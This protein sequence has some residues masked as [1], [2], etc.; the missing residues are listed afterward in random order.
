MAIKSNIHSLISKLQRGY[1][2]NSTLSVEDIDASM[3]SVAQA[4]L[5][6]SEGNGEAVIENPN[7]AQVS[8]QISD[9]MADVE[10]ESNESF[11]KAQRKAGIITGLMFSKPKEFIQRLGNPKENTS[12]KGNVVASEGRHIEAPEMMTGETMKL[13]LEAFDGTENLN[14]VYYNIAVNITASKQDDF[15]EAFF[16]TVVIHP[17]EVGVS[18]T[19]ALTSFIND[20]LRNAAGD[21]VNGQGQSVIKNI[22]NT[23]IL[24]K[25]R[26][27]LVPKYT[28]SNENN[29]AKFVDGTVTDYVDADGNK[30]KTAALAI[31]KEVEIIGLAFGDGYGLNGVTGDRTDAVYSSPEVANVY[32]RLTSKTSSKA[33]LFK[34]PISASNG[35]TFTWAQ[36]GHTKEQ[37]LPASN[38]KLF[39][40]IGNGLP[41]NLNGGKQDFSTD[42]D[43]YKG[44]TLEI[45][46]ALTGTI[47]LDTG[48]TTVNSM[49]PNIT[50]V[51]N[52]EGKTIEDA[53]TL[54]TIREAFSSIEVVG[55]DLNAYRT[56]TNLKTKG[57]LLQIDTYTR[58]FAVPFLSGYTVQGPTVHY[59]GTQNDI[60]HI[61]ETASL[62]IQR[63][64][65]D[66]VMT[67]FKIAEKL[68]I[69][70]A[71]T[72]E[73]VEY[74]TDFAADKIIDPYFKKGVI[75]CKELVDSLT[76]SSR[77]E[78]V[79]NALMNFLI[80]EAIAMYQGKSQ[81][82]GY[83]NAHHVTHGGQKKAVV[84][85]G[86]DLLTHEY[87]LHGRESNIFQISDNLL[88]MV[89]WSPFPEMKGKLFMTFSATDKI[90][91]I[92]QPD[93]L[94]FGFRAF[95]PIITLNLQ[96]QNGSITNEQTTIVRY[97]HIGTLPVLSVYDVI[98]LPET[99]QQKIS[100]N[101]NRVVTL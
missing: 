45:D 40:T 3:Q 98:N 52:A 50:G 62:C 46:F 10:K 39:I 31:G 73:G 85:V 11:T 53:S 8:D 41:T 75:D 76:S 35:G 32:I 30:F 78:D 95:S 100:V 81:Q 9:V 57:Q 20:Y 58:Y 49:V 101:V 92:D 38:Q 19:V 5:P 61:T 28:D 84:L 14:N 67:L 7:A 18:Y 33:N 55:Y 42:L 99:L 90:G 34:F 94:H 66:A 54:K 13:A 36:V 79:A 17:E 24:L 70:Q 69:T 23:D 1:T 51:K 88:M 71:S 15:A 37:K 21:P 43:S 96:R 82:G 59:T 93:I 48:N 6:D 44:Y 74:Q 97:K 27:K 60:T 65:A 22:Y 16:P 72:L 2:G 25:E 26:T 87:L 64:N 56:N 68:E 77:R 29:K 80:P 4:E 89:V 12:L 63:S 86:T 91:T 83:M 47:R